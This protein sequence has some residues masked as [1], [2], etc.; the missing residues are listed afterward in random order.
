MNAGPD[1]QVPV[2]VAASRRPARSRGRTEA[3][4]RS[5][6]DTPNIAPTPEAPPTP[7]RLRHFGY[8][9]APRPTRLAPAHGV[10]RRIMD[11]PRNLGLDLAR[12]PIDHWPVNDTNR[13]VNLTPTP[14]SRPKRQ[15]TR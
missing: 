10:E 3:S 9:H 13:Q 12:H 1:V 4:S 5:V 8:A 7:S 6:S 15:I 14:G 11:H 2:L